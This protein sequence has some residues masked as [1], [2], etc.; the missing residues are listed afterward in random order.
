MRYTL[1]FSILII[2]TL[3][4]GCSKDK[5]DTVPTLEFTSVNTT[6]LRSGNI[7]QF[8]LTFKDAEG[9][10]SNAIYIE[11]QTP[12]CVGSNFSQDYPI[13]VFPAIKNQKGEI[14]VT[15]GYNADPFP[16]IPPK[17]AKD[18]TAI[19]RFALKDRQGNVS[20]TVS[21]PPIKLYY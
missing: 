9:D 3:L 10:I 13:P 14:T 21:S 17:C 8:T 15:L 7:L 20:D 12:D 19:F 2:S 11:K 18:E 4:A 1:L 5:F 16:Q 6:E